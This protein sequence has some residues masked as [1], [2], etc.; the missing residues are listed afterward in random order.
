MFKFKKSLEIISGI[1][2]LGRITKS[3]SEVVE[4][5]SKALAK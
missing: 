2:P 4:F 5:E 3:Y 1:I